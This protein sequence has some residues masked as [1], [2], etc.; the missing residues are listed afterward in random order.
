MYYYHII[1]IPKVIIRGIDGHGGESIKRRLLLSV[2]ILLSLAL[3]FNID[4]TSAMAVK[5]VNISMSSVID[6][7]MGI[8]SGVSNSTTRDTVKILDRNTNKFLAAGAHV[9]VNNL[10]MAQM[11]D[12][13][14]RVQAF[15]N[16]NGRLPAYV[17]FGSRKI[18]I[19]TFQ[20]NIA[21]QGLKITTTVNNLTISQMKDGISRVQAFY[22]KNGRLPVYISFG[23]R[24]ILLTTFEQNIAVFGLKIKTTTVFNT[25]SISALAKSLSADSTSQYNTAVKIFNWVRDN[26]GYSF[27]Y[28]TTYGAAGTL[29]SRTGNCC[30]KTNLLVA[31]ARAAGI[32]AQYKSGYCQFS[33]GRWYGH[34]WSDLYVNGKWYAADAICHNNTLG[35]INNWNTTNFK[36]LGTYTTLPY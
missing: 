13:I 11:K 17:S 3:V 1:I 4:V 28:N 33:S 14:S 31:L 20:Q 8:T 5:Q 6:G 30:D 35:V 24:K 19:S 21:S 22:N 15:Y 36:L 16:K 25:S 23:S 12:G 27:Y 32:T 34:V 18:P 9:L 26:I 7:N 10:T 29:D 2:V